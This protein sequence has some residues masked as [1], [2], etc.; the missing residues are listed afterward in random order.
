MVKGLE[1]ILETPIK[2]P[3]GNHF[4][5]SLG[6]LDMAR[7]FLGCSRIQPGLPGTCIPI[8]SYFYLDGRETE[9]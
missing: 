3:R 7:C 9:E 6:V 5:F 2:I 1:P 4:A 8:S